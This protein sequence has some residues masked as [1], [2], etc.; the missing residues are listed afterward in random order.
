VNIN[1]DQFSRDDFACIQSV[2]ANY[3]L[4]NESSGN[5][6]G[7]YFRLTYASTPIAATVGG[8]AETAPT[9]AATGTYNYQVNRPRHL[10]ATIPML[11]AKRALAAPAHIARA[12][13]QI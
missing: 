3:N 8:T 5:S 13:L 7:V 10:R 9:S 6:S 2:F 11:S 1:S 12:P 4:A